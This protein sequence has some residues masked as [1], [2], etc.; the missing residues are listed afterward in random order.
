[1]HKHRPLEKPVMIISTDG[2]ILSVLGPYLADKKNNDT[3]ITDH[4]LKTNVEEMRDWLQPGDVFVV[5]SGFRDSVELLNNLGFK[6]EIPH[7]FKKA[8]KQHS[9]EIK[10]E[11]SGDKNSLV[12]ESANG[13]IKIW[14]VL[15]NVVPN[16]CIPYSG[17]YVRIIRALC[18]AFK[19]RLIKDTLKNQE[20]A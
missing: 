13:R 10:S 4:I 17:D 18:N 2:Y 15:E 7:F 5:D 20:L 3:S 19:L 9:T 12:M 8:E 14:K 6:T 16:S 11:T 1:M